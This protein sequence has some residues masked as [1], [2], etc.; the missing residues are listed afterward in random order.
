M[1]KLPSEAAGWLREL[2]GALAAKPVLGAELVI[3]APF[4]HLP[5][6]ARLAF[7]TSVALAAQ[8]V[9]PH[10]EG[11]Y[12]GEVSAG[13][14]RDAGVKYVVIGHSERRAYHHEGDEL[15]G[16]KV[17]AAMG[18]GLIPILCV[19]ESRGQ[20][21]AGAAEAVVLGQLAAAL[22]GVELT[23]TESLVIA[24]EPVWAIGTGLN[25][26]AEDAQEMSSAIRRALASTYPA[27]APGIRILYGGSVKPSNA[28]ELFAKPDV[29]GGLIGGAS[30]QLADFL[31]IAAAADSLTYADSGN[32]VGTPGRSAA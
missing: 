27:L 1:H 29:N 4:P 6:M 23:A 14:L 2:L 28:A 16:A 17:V 15:V 5:G 25:A 22:A 20:R 8:D 11:A 18:E 12:T 13:M 9:S 7:G 3:A 31:A 30:L 10:A 19:G 26:T 24:Y 32:G 21:D